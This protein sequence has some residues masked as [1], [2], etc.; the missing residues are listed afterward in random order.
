[1]ESSGINIILDNKRV[2]TQIGKDRIKTNQ[3]AKNSR[4]FDMYFKYKIEKITIRINI[5]YRTASKN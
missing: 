2:I 4:K 3:T 5:K 1:M